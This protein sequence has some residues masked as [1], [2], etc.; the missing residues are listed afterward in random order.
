MQ[1][2]RNISKSIFLRFFITNL[3]RHLRQIHRSRPTYPF[4]TANGEREHLAVKGEGGQTRHRLSWCRT[5]GPAIVEADLQRVA[6][7]RSVFPKKGSSQMSRKVFSTPKAAEAIK[8]SGVDAE[9]T[10]QRS[11]RV[12]VTLT[13]HV[14][15]VNTTLP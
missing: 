11:N 14:L 7:Q 1:N 12:A 9:R 3:K 6:A 2:K 13:A 15:Q 10:R 8:M 5:T 4:A